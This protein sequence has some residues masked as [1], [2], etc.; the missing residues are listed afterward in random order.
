MGDIYL[1]FGSRS[2]NG[3]YLVFCSGGP[4]KEGTERLCLDSASDGW[5]LS[6]KGLGEV[7]CDLPRPNE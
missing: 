4:E 6:G 2:K 5:R 1:I 3:T 7:T